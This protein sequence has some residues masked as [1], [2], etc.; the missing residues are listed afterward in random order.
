[1]KTC[2]VLFSC[3]CNDP[4]LNRK[5]DF[6]LIDENAISFIFLTVI[7][8]YCRDMPFKT[9]AKFVTLFLSLHLPYVYY[10]ITNNRVRRTSLIYYLIK[11]FPKSDIK[12]ILKVSVRCI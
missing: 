5:F 4:N 10:K 11:K 12:C 1:M 2:K 7:K 6:Y 3:C 8:Q 9:L